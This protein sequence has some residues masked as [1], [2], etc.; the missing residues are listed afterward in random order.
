M[1]DVIFH[2]PIIP[3]KQKKRGRLT[4]SGVERT[5]SKQKQ[6]KKLSF[7]WFNDWSAASPRQR[8]YDCRCHEV[9][10][11]TKK[12]LEKL[13]ASININSSAQEMCSLLMPLMFGVFR[14]EKHEQWIFPI[15]VHLSNYRPIVSLGD[16]KAKMFSVRL[17]YVIHARRREKLQERQTMLMEYFSDDVIRKTVINLFGNSKNR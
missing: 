8:R 2:R 5:T 12:K 1:L 13:I 3:L 16:K 15:A 6:S 14:G 4:V 7:L 9:W 11:N 10:V 17:D